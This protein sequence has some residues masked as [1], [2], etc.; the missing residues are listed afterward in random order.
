MTM[1][2]L[3]STSPSRW[4]LPFVVFGV[5]YG[6]FEIIDHNVS[7][8]IRAET[9]RFLKS[10]KHKRP[11]VS[12]PNLV[13]D[14]FTHFFG[15]EH[16]SAKCIRRSFM[17]SVFSLCF[18]F[19]F[20]LLYNPIAL[21]DSIRGL[22]ITFPQLALK[23]SKTPN[24]TRIGHLLLDLGLTGTILFLLIMWIFWC[25]IPDYIAL[26]KSRIVILILQNRPSTTFR[27]LIPIFLVDFA[28]AIWV[29]ITSIVIFQALL[30]QVFTSIQF[31]H[32]PGNVTSFILSA[33]LFSG[34]LFIVEAGIIMTTGIIFFVIPYANIFWASTI[35]SA[36]L[37]LY[38]LA[39]MLTRTFLANEKR[40]SAATHVLDIAAHPFRALGLLSGL[41]AA[42]LTFFALIILSIIFAL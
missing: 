5:V 41:F 33:L 19:I 42:F 22:I 34:V 3:A 7:P 26:L 6:F 14:T 21:S 31:Q 13:S 25:I 2:M 29:F 24:S 11:I 20:T 12:L 10:G 30:I 28:T 40:L 36:W 16:L 15:K 32:I 8:E 38:L 23:L 18:S 9:G 1:S 35:P 37:W 17:L 27:S 39:S 4:A